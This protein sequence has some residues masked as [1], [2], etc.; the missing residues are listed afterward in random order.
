MP[1]HV[2][3]R[4]AN[5]YLQTAAIERMDWLERSPGLN[6]IEHAWNKLQ[7]AIFARPDLPT[8]VP[9]LQQALLDEWARFHDKAFEGL[10]AE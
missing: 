8:T 7:T 3:A 2:E 10:L 5:E 6:P 9:E 4:V 1:D